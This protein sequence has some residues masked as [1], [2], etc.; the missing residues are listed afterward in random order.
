MFLRIWCPGLDTAVLTAPTTVEWFLLASHMTLPFID[1]R[2]IQAFSMQFPTVKLLCNLR[3]TVIQIP[4]CN[5]AVF[6]LFPVLHTFMRCLLF[7]RCGY[8]RRKA[9]VPQ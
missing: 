4:L 9:E 6:G 5:S 1:L 3:F 7:V 2:K 8:S